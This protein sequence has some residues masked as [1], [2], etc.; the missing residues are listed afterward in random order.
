MESNQHDDVIRLGDIF[1]VLWKNII[2]I[3]IITAAVF[4][5]G[6][7]YT[8]GIAQPQYASNATFLVA[9]NT[10]SSG[11]G[12]NVDYSNSLRLVTTAA[13]LV[14]EDNVLRPVAEDN[15]L[16]VGDL[17][18]MV[19]V[20]Y[21]TNSFLVTV[22]VECD[23]STLSMRLANELVESLID[24]SNTDGSGVDILFKNTIS[25]TSPAVRGTYSSPNRAL[26]LAIFLLGGLV[27]GCIAVYVKEF[28]SNKFRNRDDIEG[29]LGEKVVG[30][31]VDDKT[32]DKHV[33]TADTAPRNA[34]EAQV[35]SPLA[36]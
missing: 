8:F 26:Y 30:Y 24:V 17:R 2:L 6:I 36:R 12:E 29:Y 31:F 20:S 15:E 5:A 18:D 13:K 25:M 22:T 27:V 9:V 7:V 1:R 33:S 34:P 14:T 10:P 35:P 28:C 19:S 23:N 11:D 3:A 21:D 32:K 4:V 16:A